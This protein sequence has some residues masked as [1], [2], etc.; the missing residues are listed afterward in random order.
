MKV[1]SSS[2]PS[3]TSLRVSISLERDQS[4]AG[5]KDRLLA[6]ANIV[7]PDFT[8]DDDKQKRAPIDLI[9]VIDRSG[10]M[11]GQK[12][13]LVKQALLFVVRQLQS[14]DR[15][16]LAT[17]DSNVSLEFPL[18]PMNADGCQMAS[19]SVES[20]RAGSSTNLCGGIIEGYLTGT[21]RTNPLDV[22]SMFVFTDGEANAGIRTHAQG[23]TEEMQKLQQKLKKP[24]SVTTFGFGQDHDA[25]MLHAIAETG[26]GMY[27]YVETPEQ[28]PTLFA[29]C[30]GGLLSV[31]A[32][33]IK[34]HIMGMKSAKVVE[35]L[36]NQRSV[37]TPERDGFLVDVGDIYA[38]EAKNIVFAL[39]LD[40]LDRP[41]ESHDVVE[42]IASYYHCLSKKTE[43]LP[44]LT[45]CVKRPDK[46][47][48]VTYD[49][50]VD[51]Q[52]NRLEAL[53]AT[54][55]AR[56][57][58]DRGKLQ[59]AKD[60]INQAIAKMESSISAKD[61]TTQISVSSLRAMIPTL[62]DTGTYTSTG[63]KFLCSYD[64]SNSAQR[65]NTDHC[66]SYLDAGQLQ[67]RGDT[68][69]KQALRVKAKAF[70]GSKAKEE[71]PTVKKEEE[72]SSWFSF[73]K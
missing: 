41:V 12:L 14:E 19:K 40:G 60:A 39:E 31:V 5:S 53:T 35:V 58:A 42:V 51:K 63:S 72:T 20:I 46:V 25:H 73:F 65:S 13:D 54:G 33:D 2:G 45:A 18:T 68:V 48:H 9:C 43:L 38:G 67:S 4:Q 29:D 17:F 15:L 11:Q 71:P 34:L 26:R 23:I 56:E 47:E 66:S 55:T 62:R 44:T 50:E 52:K 3:D 64:S 28:I 21:S 7:A 10:S 22:C 59:E 69:T 6:M 61:P 1:K 57:L 16:A 49:V 32:Q 36:G 37:L 8:P 70:S 24:I 30:L 27:Y